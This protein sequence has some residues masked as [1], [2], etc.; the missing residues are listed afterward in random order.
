MQNLENINAELAFFYQKIY[1]SL[2]CAL[3]WYDMYT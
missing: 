1:V 2:H 3:W